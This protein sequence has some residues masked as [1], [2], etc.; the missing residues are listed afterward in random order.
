MPTGPALAKVLSSSVGFGDG[1]VDSYLLGGSTGTT[2][3]I[4]YQDKYV[5]EWEKEKYRTA[6]ALMKAR[7]NPTKTP[8]WTIIERR[9]RPHWV[10]IST[11][12]AYNAT[13]LVIPNY[14]R[15]QKYDVLFIPRTQERIYVGATPSDSSAASLTRGFSG[16]IAQAVLANDRARIMTNMH[17]EGSSAPDPRA[18]R[19]EELTFYVQEIKHASGT[20]YTAA[21]TPIAGDKSSKRLQEIAA[22]MPVHKDAISNLLW[23]GGTAGDF[24]ATSSENWGHTH[25]AG[26]LGR[27][28]TYIWD[29]GGPFTYT[30]FASWA[31]GPMA[32]QN[33]KE[34]LFVTS[35]HV[36]NIVNSW[37]TPHLQM[38]RDDKTFGM[39]LEYLMVNGRKVHFVR[40]QAFDE[41]EHM[42]GWGFIL[43]V[44]HITWRPH[45][46]NGLNFATHLKKDVYNHYNGKEEFKDVW[47][48]H[49]GWE[50]KGEAGFG[51]CYGITH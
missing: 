40:E 9:P 21:A 7:T 37:A 51:F 50:I 43:P 14:E 11:A 41:N 4:L 45:V 36:M 30:S 25:S 44:N 46:G 34:V 35:S 20:T 22:T 27:I 47:V 48:T 32:W 29:T 26:L 33:T 16:S 8:K 28:N 31:A 49:G 23:L 6:S 19:P 18:T 15:I 42:S 1:A 38:S 13:T 17:P 10:T 24:T 12:A 3:E 39:E 5:W 2:G